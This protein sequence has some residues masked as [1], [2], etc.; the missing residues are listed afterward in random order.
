[1]KQKDEIIQIEQQSKQ[2]QNIRD[3]IINIMNNLEV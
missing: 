1:M 2:I 3:D